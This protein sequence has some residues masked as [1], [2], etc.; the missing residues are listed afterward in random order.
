VTAGR[1][2]P[3]LMALVVALVLVVLAPATGLVAPAAVR[4]AD[5]GL[6]VVTDATYTVRP[7][8]GNVGVAVAVNARNRTTETRTRR[9][10][11]DHT[12]LAVQPGATNIRISGP[13]GA[14]VRVARRTEEAT[15]LRIDFGSRLYSGKGEDMK[16]DL[17]L[18]GRGEGASP[19]VRVGSGLVTLPVWAFASDGAHGSSVAV[20]FPPGW[21][22]SVESGKLPR[23]STGADGGTVLEAGPLAAPLEFFAFVSAQRPAAYVDRPLSVPVSGQ[24]VDLVLQ[25][26]KDDPAWA[27]RTGSLFTDALPVLRSDIGLPWPAVEPLLI[28]ETAGRAADAAA[29]AFDPARN[30][31]DVAYWADSGAVIHQAAH[32]WFNGNLL[33]D[34]WANE[35]FATFYALRAA[36]KLGEPAAGPTMTDEARAA[37]FPLDA[38]GASDGQGTTKAADAYGYAASLE[39]ANAL[40]DRVGTDVL[41]AVWS[42]AA[43]GTGAYQPP[44]G[45]RSGGVGANAATGAETGTA[46]GTATGKATGKAT[47]E[48]V[49]GAPG[50]RA[51]LDLL[52]ARSGQDLT[53]LW[54]QWV[55]RPDEA[56]SLDARA[57]ARASYG[58][59]LALADGWQLPRAIRDALRA[60]QFDTAEKLMADARTVLAQRKA[61]AAMAERD[62]LE[63]PD[64]TMRGL[65]ESGSM[66]DASAHA[67][68]QRAAMLAIAEAEASRSV[69]DDI[70]SRIGMLGEHPEQSLRE[71]GLLLAQDDFEGSAAAS[72]HAYR[73][74]TSAW[75]EGRRRALMAAAALATLVV[76]GSAIVGTF[77]RSRRE[78][79]SAAS[80]E[81]A[82][83]G[84]RTAPA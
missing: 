54:R 38:W 37:S 48:S 77:R 59:T 16:L 42:D 78:A 82:S 45:P 1:I 32:G 27:N 83:T 36:A 11:F 29:G 33:A 62:G 67:E 80:S 41:A 13:K 55:V 14:R 73:D 68:A 21:D 66:A 17:D 74:W 79:G 63:L 58:R 6:T 5:P 69:D 71:A 25:A 4:A 44:D 3:A 18:P 31:M 2:R 65:F 84:D 35:G 39:L 81:S 28:H 60:W 40:A 9:F 75:E 53:P 51:L 10:F 23:T 19:Q 64:V 50:W 7:E 47:P 30:R 56:A 49:G 43:A 46:T 57:A 24:Q 61:V 26:W 20:R 76:L 52:E 72:N 15:L 22:V 8:D 12:F 70:L 34:R